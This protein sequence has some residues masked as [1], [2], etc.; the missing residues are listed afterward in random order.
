ML[1][2]VATSFIML[3]LLTRQCPLNSVI[4]CPAR[5]IPLS[6]PLR[7][8][9]RPRI[10]GPIPSKGRLR[11]RTEWKTGSLLALRGT[12]QAKL[13]TRVSSTRFPRCPLSQENAHHPL[14]PN[15]S[16]LQAMPPLATPWLRTIKQPQPLTT[17]RIRI[18]ISTASKSKA[19]ATIFA[20]SIIGRLL[21]KHGQR[22]L[23]KL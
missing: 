13:P 9:M 1:G 21:S 16:T 18:S 23:S 3:P 19:L 2:E 7:V 4:S 10:R 6:K 15:N 17:N 12:L 8:T 22:Q 11:T 5:I 14:Q 20:V